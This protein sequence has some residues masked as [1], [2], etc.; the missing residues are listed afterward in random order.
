MLKIYRS[1]VFTVKVIGVFKQLGLDDQDWDGATSYFNTAKL[2]QE[3]IEQLLGDTPRAAAY[4]DIN[5]ALEQNLEA[6]FEKFDACVSDHVTECVNEAIEAAMD[7]ANTATSS[8]LA[9][10]VEELKAKVGPLRGQ[11]TEAIKSLKNNWGRRNDTSNNSNNNRGERSSAINTD[12]TK[13]QFGRDADKI[14]W[15][16]NL[17]IDESW[18]RTKKQNYNRLLKHHKPE[19][20]KR[21]YKAYLQA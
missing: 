5:A 21:Q 12:D 7:Q 18:N 2:N 8:G 10:Q 9:T 20:H 11:L 3:E 14:N 17:N 6:V 4:S 16:D 13:L 19:E 15:K 1:R